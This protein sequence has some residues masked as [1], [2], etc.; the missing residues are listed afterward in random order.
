M[1][2]LLVT[3][4]LSAVPTLASGQG[5]IIPRPCV[6]APLPPPCHGDVCGRPVPVA[7]T[8]CG[9]HLE[10]VSNTV[11][12][13]LADRVLRYEVTEV[14]RNS[15]SLVGEADYI[16]PLPAGAAFED[17][18][19]SINGELVAGETMSADKARGIYE[20]IVRRQRDP[21]L[22]EWMGT[23]MLRT[24]IFPIAPG[25]EKKVVVRY[26]SVI[27][28]EG[29]ALRIDYRRGSDPV[30]QSGARISIRPGSNG[31]DSGETWSRFVL[32]YARSEQ[33]GEPYSPTHTL[34]TRDDRG[35]R[36]VE[37]RGTGAEVTLLIPLRRSNAAAMSVLTHRTAGERG[38]ALVTIT[39]PATATSTALRDVT[40]VVDVSGS[41]S[42]RKLQQAKAAGR[43]LLESLHEGDRFRII[44]FASDVRE[45]RDAQWTT[46]TA[47]NVR[48]A[49]RYLDNLRAEGSTNISGALEVA[50]DAPSSSAN[51]LPLVVFVTDG[52]PTVGERNPAAIGALAARL[53]GNAR[54][55]SVGVT[56]GVNAALVE[57]LAVEGRGT[58]HFVRDDESVEQVVSLLAQRLSAPVLT[59]VRIVANGV[60]LTQLLPAGP[61]DVFA[62][63]DLVV[64]ARY[65][66]SG[67]ATIRL[68]GQS[69]S[70]PVTWTTRAS[71]AE[72]ERNNPFVAR[73]WAAQ[74]IGWLAAEKRRNGG[75]KELDDEIRTLGERY[76]IPT[77]FSSYLVIEPGMV[78][79]QFTPSTGSAR[80]IAGRDTRI[81]N[82]VAAA[83][84]VANQRFEAARAAAEQRAAK[85]V[86]AL[87]VSTA[88][89]SRTV[90]TRRFQLVNGVWTDARSTDSL[91]VVRVKPYSALYFDLM[92]RIPDLAPIFALGDR[93]SVA[94][95]GVAILLDE[96]GLEKA[97]APTLQRIARDW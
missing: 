51:R 29:D 60:R 95:R 18:K 27:T 81:S 91:R 79:Q 88:G 92:Q 74:R 25:E 59:D 85:S 36:I 13:T 97:D 38:F 63:Q 4:L 54:V 93:V 70:G 23:G 9:V 66:G 32:Q 80:D 19:L 26:Q 49:A 58:A 57:Q 65:E 67:D 42:G 21:A 83:P 77:E 35:M 68:E 43:A 39:P 1:R 94:G 62:G 6:P 46:A 87:D 73:L 17:L 55:F 71:F 48:A 16:F 61:I 22:V 78:A 82:A 11:R 50:L 12:V 72:R 34:R 56:A 75:S 10:R 47:S 3:L 64:L 33:F 24:R 86:A 44:D 14:F 5:R 53:R 52:E 2:R 69:P 90:G 15:G 45:F 30:A 28:R 20:E 96:N 7:T 76:G 41:M 31:E 84:P 89:E 8:T 40:F 37:A